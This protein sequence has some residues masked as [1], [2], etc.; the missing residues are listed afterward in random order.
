MSTENALNNFW[1]A[2]ECSV[3]S[4]FCW[5]TLGRWTQRAKPVLYGIY[6]FIPFF[7]QA[8]KRLKKL[9]TLPP[10]QYRFGPSAPILF[11][12][13]S[14]TVFS[15]VVGCSNGIL[16]KCVDKWTGKSRIHAKHFQFWLRIEERTEIINRMHFLRSRFIASIWSQSNEG[17]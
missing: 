13:C 8:S 5:I 17:C 1:S 2:A 9:G 7:F 14:G 12:F 11:W 4:L 3:A 15:S 6:F 16:I 10:P